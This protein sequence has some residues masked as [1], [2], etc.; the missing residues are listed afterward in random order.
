MKS[1]WDSAW[2]RL[3]EMTDETGLLEHARFGVPLRAEGY[4]TDD[5]A[6]ALLLLSRL[7]PALQRS[8]RR[9]ALTYLAF[10][11]DAQLPD[12]RFR[13]E[14][15]FD[16]T[17]Q[18]DGEAE[19]PTARALNALAEASDR[20]CFEDLRK[21]ARWALERAL[22]A[23]AAL[24]HPR[25]QAMA[26][27]G[28]LAL[29]EPSEAALQTARLLGERLLE[30]FRRHG[31]KWP[32]PD[33]ILSYENFRP[34]EALYRWGRRFG[35]REA[36]YWA[37]KGLRLLDTLYWSRDAEGA[38]FDPVGNRFMRRGEAKPLFDQQPIEAWAAAEAYACFHLWDR[39]QGVRRWFL[40]RNRLRSPLVDAFG[41]M[42]GLTPQGPNDNRGAESL[43]AFLHTE[44]LYQHLR[45]EAF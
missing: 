43:L 9:L 35:S 32:F 33:E 41:V 36:R 19:D 11:L 26:L 16:R 29:E 27:I 40:G 4:T 38:F 25:A 37:R 1:W 2:S 28:L 20:L 34:V 8:A 23:A 44:L 24:Q 7:D 30:A 5:N 12:G 14:M 31:L 39:L 21:A 15:R 17:W 13:N 45:V 18:D 3:H 22:P 6:R 10:L 42:D